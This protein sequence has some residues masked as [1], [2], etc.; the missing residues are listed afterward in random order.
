MSPC[1]QK[2]GRRQIYFKYYN[3]PKYTAENVQYVTQNEWMNELNI[4][5]VI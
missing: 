2:S 3:I 1:V 5:R 4:Y